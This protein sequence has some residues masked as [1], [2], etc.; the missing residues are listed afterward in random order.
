MR[1]AGVAILT[2][3]VVACGASTASPPS[4]SPT[5]DQVTAKY[6]ALI[7][8]YWIRL[9]A[10]DEAT[11]TSNVAAVVCLGNSSPSSPTDIA[12]VDPV[13]CGERAAAILAVHQKFQDDLQL[14]PAPPRFMTEDRTIRATLP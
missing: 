6:V 1:A 13:R 5:T 12:N 7:H 3:F 9:M 11:A 2:C 8:D 10:A 4:P 14:T